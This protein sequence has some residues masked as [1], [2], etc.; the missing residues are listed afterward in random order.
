M[1]VRIRSSRSNRKKF[2]SSRWIK[3]STLFQATGA[4]KKNTPFFH[5]DKY[6]QK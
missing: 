3:L 1:S 6:I 4:N 2:T 5:H